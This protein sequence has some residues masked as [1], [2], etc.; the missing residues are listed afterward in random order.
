MLELA[1]GQGDTGLQ[2]A[3]RLEGRGRVILADQSQGMLEAAPAGQ[4]TSRGCPPS[5]R[6]R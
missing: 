6:P 3:A 2:A 5:S 1:A 4:P